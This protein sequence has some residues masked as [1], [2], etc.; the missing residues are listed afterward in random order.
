MISSN[1]FVCT[2]CSYE[3]NRKYNLQLHTSS[4]NAC[5]KRLQKTCHVPSESNVGD[6]G[7]NVGDRVVNV[8]D[9]RANVGGRV[10]NVGDRRA[11]VGDRDRVA[12][13]GDRRANVCTKCSRPYKRRID[14]DKHIEK[15]KG[16][17]NLQ[18]PICMKVFSSRFTKYEHIKNVKCQPPPREEEDKDD[19]IER[20]EK[21]NELLKSNR[22]I[23]IQN[24]TT[25]NIQINSYDK[26]SI[27]HITNNVIKQIF[28]RN[29]QEAH[30]MLGDIIRQIYKNEKYPENDSIR[31]I[32]GSK[33]A[34]AQVQKGKKLITLPALEVLETLLTKS[35]EVCGD[36]LRDCEDDGLIHGLRCSI[37]K[38]LMDT[39]ATDDREGDKENRAKYIPYV[40]S[41]LL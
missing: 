7:A 37:I 22:P 33:S 24:N 40:K 4:P 11:N 15:C 26:P 38:E 8:G 19:K 35:S 1:R 36:G 3:T 25:N 10:A 28:Y 30:L 31:L 18:C 34:F 20:L 17:N 21:E 16:I 2:V 29:N 14:C 13:V 6:S 32:E 41:A 23:I 12:N 39:L 5:A 27:E 9:R